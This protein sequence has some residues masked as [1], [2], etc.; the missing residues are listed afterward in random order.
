MSRRERGSATLEATV[1]YPMVLLLILLAVNAA[2]W[3]HAR[4][5][6]LAAAQEGLRA[7]R[8]HGAGLTTGQT[9]ARD[10]LRQ[11][12][13]NFLTSPSVRAERTGGSVQMVVTGRAIS[14]IPL[15]DLGVEQVARAP[16]ERWTT[17]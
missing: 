9:A 3:F 1:I 14:L 11:T 7:G 6:A 4:A 13:G 17:P 2:M 10:F 16:L 5:I 8:A 12:G 15:L